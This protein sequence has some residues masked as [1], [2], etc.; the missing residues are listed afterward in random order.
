[1]ANHDGVNEQLSPFYQCCVRSEAHSLLLLLVA[2]HGCTDARS[3]RVL[4]SPV[5]GLRRPRH[6]AARR[7]TRRW[8]PSSSAKG[9]SPSPRC[10]IGSRNTSLGKYVISLGKY[11]ISLGKY[12]IS[13]RH[14]TVEPYLN[15]PETSWIPLVQR[16][17]FRGRKS[18]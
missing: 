6:D 12:V 15:G 2:N 1:L 13:P 3:D 11:V 9:P 5:F 16:I 7:R 8:G 17:V 14:G 4:R 18:P 10:E